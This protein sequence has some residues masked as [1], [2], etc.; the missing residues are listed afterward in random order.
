MER[1]VLLG[2]VFVFM[3]QLF[4]CREDVSSPK[5]STGSSPIV[6]KNL[7]NQTISNETISNS[8]GH[9][10]SLTNCSNITI[11]NCL[12]GPALKNG[13][14]LYNC[15]NI[16]VTNCT[17]SSV[18]TG[19]SANLS[20]GIKITYNNIKNI[21]GPYPQ[22]QMAQ[23]NEVSGGGNMI[24]YNVVENIAGQSYPEDAINIYKSNGIAGDP[25]Q[26]I[27]N[28]IRGGGPSI[29]GSGIMTG[30]QGGSYI[31]VKDNILV[32]PGSYGI[33]IASGNHISI[34]NNKIFGKKQTFTDVGLSVWNQY[35]YD[36]FSDTIMNNEVNFTN[37][38][39]VLNNFWNGGNC[40]EII[41]WSTNFYNPNLTASILP[42]I[43]TITG[44]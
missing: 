7:S 19:I 17:M 5:P 4:S 2:V 31:L 18:S 22:G 40:G 28:R 16:R 32:N 25:I 30:D 15:T 23:F 37:K 41:G 21:Q 1:S 6:W 3:F 29:S 38:R 12:L 26:V 10:I 39:G 42:A 33:T 11:R 9:C 43:L 14:Y 34:K 13:V 20:S 8:I 44:E 36:C 24:N 27:G 35:Y